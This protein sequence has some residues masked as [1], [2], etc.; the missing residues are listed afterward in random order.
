MRR[1]P[2]TTDDSTTEGADGGEQAARDS[3]ADLIAAV[4]L[5]PGAALVTAVVNAFFAPQVIGYEMQTQNVYLGGMSSPVITPIPKFGASPLD[6]AAGAI[7]REYREPIT[8]SIGD[9]LDLDDLAGRVADRLWNDLAGADKAFDRLTPH[10]D[11]IARMVRDKLSDRLTAR[12]MAEYDEQQR[13]MAEA[14]QR[15]RDRAAAAPQA[16][17]D[18]GERGE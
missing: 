15:E 14:W 10:A 3:V 1:T 17:E 2:V 9:R 6:Q 12:A 11:H 4:K 5:D 16:I 7:F 13:Q 8:R 18:G